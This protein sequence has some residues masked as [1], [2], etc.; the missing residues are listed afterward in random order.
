MNVLEGVRKN[1]KSSIHLMAGLIDSK[2]SIVI[3]ASAGQPW[4]LLE[5]DKPSMAQ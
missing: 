2:L 1:M 4:M 3:I 5:D